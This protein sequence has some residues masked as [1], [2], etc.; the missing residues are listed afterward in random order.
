MAD[1]APRAELVFRPAPPGVR[2]AAL[3]FTRA[4]WGRL[5]GFYGAVGGLHLLGFGII[6]YSSSTWP[7]LAGLGFAAYMLGLRHAFDADHIAA[8]DDTVRYL[9]Q[10][11]KRPLGIGFFFSLGHSAVVFALTLATIVAAS[12]V[13]QYLPQLQGLG[14]IIGAAVSGVFL[15]LVGFLNL[16]VLIDIIRAWRGSA[17]PGAAHGHAHM[18]E[19]LAQ[20]GFFNRLLGGRLQRFINHS[21]QMFP[22]GVLFGL[23]FDT[24]SE[25]AL[26]AMTVGASASNLPLAAVLAL[27]LLFAAGMSAMD[28]TDG[29]LMSKAYEWAFV[30]PLRKIYYNITIT[31]LS[32]AVA[33]VIGSIELL[34]VMFTA[35]GLHGYFVDL[36]VGVE[37][38]TLG[39]VVVGL[40]L[41]AWTV[42]AL[43]WRFG[44]I[45]A[46]FGTAFVHDEEHT[47]DSG[48]RHSHGHF[49][50]Q[51]GQLA[52]RSVVMPRVLVPGEG[53]FA[54][55]VPK[56]PLISLRHLKVT[57]RTR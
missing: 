50:S 36:V 25:I 57:R 20:R 7:A 23:G 21:W 4:E 43:L 53:V 12:A 47:H 10:K 6:I 38:D 2:C 28:T 32:V 41:I 26:L 40:F 42:S 49:H 48:M 29:V 14:G 13:R 39:Y 18:A 44:R 15:W 56:G 54:P 45:E 30:N 22:L 3:N 16:M 19:L 31:S 1:Q 24:A 11:G 5:G 33:L 35:L 17:A 51:A 8:V 46:R 34:Q 55:P 27:P 52:P 9:L 37:F